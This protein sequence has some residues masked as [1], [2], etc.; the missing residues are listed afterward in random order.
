MWF[1]KAEGLVGLFIFIF[2]YVC[3]ASFCKEQHSHVP[4]VQTQ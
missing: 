2:M 4:N 3:I 1:L